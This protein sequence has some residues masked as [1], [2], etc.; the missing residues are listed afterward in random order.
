MPCVRFDGT[1]P[2]KERQPVIDRF[3]KDPSIRVM[4]LTLSCGAV[5]LTL[6]VA[7]RAY[8]M[9]PH[10]NPTIEEQALARIHRLGQTKEVTTV[11]FYVKDSIEEQVM[12]L[13]DS[14]KH[15]ANVLLSHHDTGQV[16][17]NLDGLHVCQSPSRV[18]S[19]CLCMI[20]SNTNTETETT[21][22]TIILGCVQ[23]VYGSLL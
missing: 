16:D 8:L 14:K 15:L 21:E 20:V 13:Q 18:V 9:E 19:H 11:R 6:T 5:G 17:D 10:W 22:S 4:L 2:Q 7:T 12:R 23:L 3:R 1:V